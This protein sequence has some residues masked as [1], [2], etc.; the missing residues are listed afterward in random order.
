MSTDS[1]NANVL[2]HEDYPVDSYAWMEKSDHRQEKWLHS[3]NEEAETFL[4]AGPLHEKIRTNI[5][6]RLKEADIVGEM[7]ASAS[8][9]FF[10]Y[11]GKDDNHFR[12]M[13]LRKGTETPE[14]I[15]EKSS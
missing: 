8:G 5:D 15:F 6:D 2:S 4:T 12:L 3:K 11:R 1:K 7:K 14:T 13:L 9:L 10:L